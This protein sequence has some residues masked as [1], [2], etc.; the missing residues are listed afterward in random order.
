MAGC[1]LCL[2]QLGYLIMWGDARAVHDPHD[3]HMALLQLSV[4]VA[5]V[6]VALAVNLTEAAWA[7]G[8]PWPWGLM[9]LFGFAGLLVVWFLPSR[10]GDRAARGFAVGLLPPDTPAVAGPPDG[11]TGS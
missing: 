10:T 7:E 9:A 5:A 3:R 11:G 6:T 1:I 2:A 4:T 8:H